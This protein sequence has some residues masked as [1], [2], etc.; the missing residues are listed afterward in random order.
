M[1]ANKYWKGD[2]FVNQKLQTR[3]GPANPFPRSHSSN[4]VP[5]TA[6]SLLPKGQIM[7]GQNVA[8]T[9]DDLPPAIIPGD[10][11]SNSSTADEWGNEFDDMLCV[12]STQVS[13]QVLMCGSG[14]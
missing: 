11:D 9:T 14:K 10:E 3:T 4:A 12:L 2:G 8:K 5:T 7:P 1:C 13:L 6:T